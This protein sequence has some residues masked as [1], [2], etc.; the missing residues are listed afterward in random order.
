LDAVTVTRAIIHQSREDQAKAREAQTL[1][2]KVRDDQFKL[3]QDY[4]KQLTAI[5]E[6]LSASTPAGKELSAEQA[7][8]WQ[9]YN[10]RLKQYDNLTAD[11]AKRYPAEQ[12]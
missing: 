5:H 8:A 3:L 1:A 2:D 7:T 12:K 6:E 9:E 11:F 10:K 4:H